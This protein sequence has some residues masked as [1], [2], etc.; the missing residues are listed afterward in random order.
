MRL[1]SPST[2]T[3]LLLAAVLAGCALPP[4]S[5]P[6]LMDVAERPAEKALLGG[7]RAYDDAQYPQAEA[8]LKQALAAGLASPRDRAAAHKHLAF[9]YC[10]SQRLPA[11]ETEFRAARRDDPGFALSRAEAGHPLWGPVWLRARN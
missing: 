10:T 1:R 4:A 7:M 2:L 11:C 6:G 9:I 5:P 8:L 3:P